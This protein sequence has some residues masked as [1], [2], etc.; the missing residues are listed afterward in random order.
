MKSILLFLCFLFLSVTISQAEVIHEYDNSTFLHVGVSALIGAGVDGFLYYA[1]EPE[2]RKQTKIPR[3]AF[4]FISCSAVGVVKEKL[5]YD[6]NV[7]DLI[8]DLVGCGLGVYGGD[9]F[10]ISVD[11]DNDKTVV[12]YTQHW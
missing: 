10:Y 9:E 2:V 1:T 4:S 8:G 11:S 6:F 7:G 12:S 5:D 3:R